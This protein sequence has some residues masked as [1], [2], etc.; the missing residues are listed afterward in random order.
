LHGALERGEFELYYQPQVLLTDRR[1]IGYEA[2]L[3]WH[4]PRLGAI[5][6]CEFIPLAER[7]GSILPIGEWVLRTACATAATWDNDLRIAVNVSSLQ[8][9]QPNLPAVIHEALLATGLLAGRLEIELTESLLV[10]DRASALHAL[11]RIKALGVRLALD[12]FGT[13]YSS[14]DVLRQFPFDKIKLDKSFVD[15]VERNPQ[16][17]AILHAMLTLGRALAIPILVEGVE[18]AHQLAILQKEGC[19]KV[20]GYLI[21]R[22]APIGQLGHGAPEQLSA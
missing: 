1:V 14:M 3:R 4:H 16:A 15:D 17:R 20:Q 2:L 19:T 5:P 7:S 6:P 22:P 9:R 11:R 18:T 13:G 10:E 12:D 21:G 8:L